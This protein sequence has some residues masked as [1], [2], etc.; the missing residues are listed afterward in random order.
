MLQGSLLVIFTFYSLSAALAQMKKQGQGVFKDSLDGAFDF[1][2]FL[3]EVN[4]FVP[5]PYIITE[6]AVGGFG[7]ALGLVFIRKQPPM[8]DTVRSIV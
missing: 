1:S 7:G 6:P 2:N 5:V 4:G 8:I 3:M